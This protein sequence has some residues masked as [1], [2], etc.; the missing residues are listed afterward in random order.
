[1]NRICRLFLKKRVKKIG[2]FKLKQ[3]LEKPAVPK[4][5][6]RNI[7]RTSLGDS[8]TNVHSSSLNIF[9]KPKQ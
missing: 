7:M 9:N 6:R 3:K 2:D 1:M 4:S 8:R 5:I